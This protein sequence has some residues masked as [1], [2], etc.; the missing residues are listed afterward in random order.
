MLALHLLKEEPEGRLIWWAVLVGCAV[1]VVV[2][3]G[4]D[5]GSLPG[6]AEFVSTVLDALDPQ[7]TLLV[8]GGAKGADTL[9]GAWAEA[10]GI[11]VQVF[12]ADWKSYGASAGALRNTVMLK[13]IRP[14]LVVA[15]P[16]GAGTGDCIRQATERGLVVQKFKPTSSIPK[17]LRKAVKAGLPMPFKVTK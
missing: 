15:F 7:P 10:H 13:Q 8:H 17:R 14:D 1:K 9:A 11:E 2:T 4:R 12:E 3:G 6:E 16:G 5:F